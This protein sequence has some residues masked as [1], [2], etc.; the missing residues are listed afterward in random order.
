L[1]VSSRDSAFGVMVATAYTCV[2]DM[3]EGTCAQQQHKYEEP[4]TGQA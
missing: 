4:H 1:S 2:R 3:L